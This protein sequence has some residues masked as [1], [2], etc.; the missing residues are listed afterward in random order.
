MIIVLSIV[1]SFF[2][3]L[4]T[5]IGFT[6]IRVEF[7]KYLYGPSKRSTGKIKIQKGDNSDKVYAIVVSKN[8]K[9]WVHPSQSL[10]RLGYYIG[11]D[12]ET[13]P[14]EELAKYIERNDINL[15]Y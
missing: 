15:T 7:Y 8:T 5:A 11:Q 12:V 2:T 13:I 3:A 1:V 9:R 4:M 14:A 6:F 10:D